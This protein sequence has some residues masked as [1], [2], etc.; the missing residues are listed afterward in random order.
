MAVCT[1]DRVVLLYDEH[2]ERKDKF[3]TK[4]SDSKVHGSG[5]DC[6]YC[7]QGLVFMLDFSVGPV[8]SRREKSGELVIFLLFNIF[9][10]RE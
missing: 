7:M 4:P 5:Y 1:V 3:S 10:S 2:G 6:R 8:H 9:V